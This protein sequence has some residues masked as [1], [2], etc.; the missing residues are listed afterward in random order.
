MAPLKGTWR[1]YTPLEIQ[2]GREH[3][4]RMLVQLFTTLSNGR[5]KYLPPLL[6]VIEEIGVSHKE[7]L[8]EARA[9]CDS[10]QSCY[11]ELSSTECIRKVR[12]AFKEAI[13]L[14]KIK[15]PNPFRRV[16]LPTSDFIKTFSLP[17]GL[18]FDVMRSV[19]EFRREIEIAKAKAL[20]LSPSEFRT[21][22]KFGCL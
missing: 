15:Q 8:P 13:R 9:A 22:T 18:A 4:S 2:D 6:T 5:I 16:P 11:R 7:L 14:S 10:Y 17:K 1:K 21:Q 12:K 3:T 20:G 19:A